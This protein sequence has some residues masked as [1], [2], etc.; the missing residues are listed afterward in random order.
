MDQSVVPPLAGS[1]TYRSFRN[2]PAPELAFNDLFFGQGELVIDPFATGSFSGQ[3]VFSP[4]ARMLLSG[5]SSAGNPFAL[6]FQGIGDGEGATGW[7]YDYVAYVVPDW[8]NG[9]DQRPAI[10]GSV[11]RTV[12][13]GT[14][15]AGVVASWIA[16]K[17]D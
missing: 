15:P 3:L 12:S 17:R 4:V 11:I 16:V 5:T 9:V 8:P 2:R 13:H 10:V 14:N 1:W 6:R 7:I